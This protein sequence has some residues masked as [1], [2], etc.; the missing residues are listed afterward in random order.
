LTESNHVSRSPPD[1]HKI[2]DISHRTLAMNG[3]ARS[4]YLEAPR[5]VPTRLQPAGSTLE[6][7]YVYDSV[8]REFEELERQ[9]LVEVV[10]A[11][12]AVDSGDRLI[13]GMVFVRLR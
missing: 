9:G 5:G 7:P 11:E 12:I 3:L 13:G 1:H 10:S 4:I 6:N 2:D 8:A